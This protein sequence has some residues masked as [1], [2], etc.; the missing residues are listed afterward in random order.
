MGAKRAPA[1]G[2]R[3]EPAAKVIETPTKGHTS[4][5]FNELFGM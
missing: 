3:A 2:R 1:M 4:K 5:I